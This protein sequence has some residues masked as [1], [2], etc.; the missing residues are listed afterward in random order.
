MQISLLACSFHACDGGGG[1]GGVLSCSL[2]HIWMQVFWLQSSAHQDQSKSVRVSSEYK[3]DQVVVI[4]KLLCYILLSN[5]SM[6]ESVCL[7]GYQC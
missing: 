3:R 1:G 6:C 5:V 7:D 2:I 4:L